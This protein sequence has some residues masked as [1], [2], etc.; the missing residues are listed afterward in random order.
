MHEE[1]FRHQGELSDTSLQEYT[2][3]L[4]LDTTRFAQDMATQSGGFEM[5]VAQDM[6]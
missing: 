2:Q 4:S 3:A 5:A 6:K 1:L